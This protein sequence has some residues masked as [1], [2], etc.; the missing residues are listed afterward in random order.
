[1]S[2]KVDEIT[3]MCWIAGK[4]KTIKTGDNRAFLLIDVG[5]NSKFLPCTVFDAPPLVDILSRYKPDDFIKVVGFVRGWSQKK[6]D[7]WENHV[8][9][10]ITEV[11][12]PKP[13]PQ[14]MKHTVTSVDDDEVPF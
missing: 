3:N 11:K 6:N 5:E 4:I 13:K 14:P 1:M 9:I 10:R 2:K 7:T 12:N 8:D